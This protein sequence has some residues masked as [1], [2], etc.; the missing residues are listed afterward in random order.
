[1]PLTS[2]DIEDA[3]KLGVNRYL[4]Q[5][6]QKIMSPANPGTPL[7][8]ADPVDLGWSLITQNAGPPVYGILKRSGGDAG[9]GNWHSS[10]GA[11]G[12]VYYYELKIVN[13]VQLL[14]L[15]RENHCGYSVVRNQYVDGNGVTNNDEIVTVYFKDPLPPYSTVAVY[16]IKRKNMWGGSQ[17]NPKFE[18]WIKRLVHYGPSFAGVGW[19][20]YEFVYLPNDND[21]KQVWISTADPNVNNSVPIPPVAQYPIRLNNT[22]QMFFDE[23]GDYW[24]DSSLHDIASRIRG[25]VQGWRDKYKIMKRDYLDVLYKEEVG[26]EIDGW[27]RSGESFYEPKFWPVR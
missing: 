3:L 20:T 6:V 4:K 25:W 12:N 8:E 15:N 27:L 2:Q 26:D 21:E 19:G 18:Y 7:A 9:K 5:I 22:A 10:E 17:A 23:M 11:P 16:E 1:M 14:F 13:P 24:S